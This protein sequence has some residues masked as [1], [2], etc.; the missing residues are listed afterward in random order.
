MQVS[1]DALHHWLWGGQWVGSGVS[2]LNADSCLTC[3]WVGEGY[4][5]QEA[6]AAHCNALNPTHQPT[7]PPPGVGLLVSRMAEGGDPRKGPHSLGLR[8]QDTLRMGALKV[9]AVAAQV[10]G[11]SQMGGKDEAWGAR[12][13]LQHDMIPVR[14][15]W[16][17]GGLVGG[18]LRA[19]AG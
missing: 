19:V 11:E 16:G 18:M 17:W 4:C 14:W 8:L 9:E 12:T 10:R 3:W 13:F 15:G 5:R 1:G 6:S 2:R 7:P